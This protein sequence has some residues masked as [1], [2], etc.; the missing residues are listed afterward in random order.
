MGTSGIAKLSRPRSYAAYERERLF[1]VLDRF[2]DQSVRWVSGP[3]GAGKS[4]L[5]SSWLDRRKVK[6]CW[7]RVDDRDADPASMFHY[8]GEAEAQLNSRDTRV[9][10]HFTPEYARGMSVFSHRFFESFFESVPRPFVLV[11]DDYHD[12]PKNS[13]THEALL[14]GLEAVPED[15]GVVIL[16]R[17]DPPAL[18]ARLAVSETMALLAPADLRLNREEVAG[19]LRQQG[20]T[21]ETLISSIDSLAEGWPAGIQ[22]LLAVDGGPAVSPVP[23]AFLFDYFAAE[24]FRRM[25]E[26]HRRIL[27]CA[28]LAPPCSVAMVELIS[29]EPTAGNVLD[30]L[31]RRNYFVTREEQKGEPFYRFHPLFQDFLA[32][33]LNRSIPPQ[34]QAEWRH[35]AAEHLERI[36][37]PES[38]FPLRLALGDAQGA[39]ALVLG[40]AESMLKRGLHR[41]LTRWTLLLKERVGANSPLIDYW[42]GL[43]LVHFSPKEAIG[44]IESAFLEFRRRGDVDG[45][46]KSWVAAI[47]AIRYDH[48]GDHRRLDPW[49]SVLPQ[50]Q[51]LH[52]L[53]P[54]SPLELSVIWGSFS[55][56]SIRNPQHPAYSRIKERA[57]SLID[58]P[59]QDEFQKSRL[60]ISFAVFTFHQG[61]LYEARRLL[62]KCPIIDSTKLMPEVYSGL[63][64]ARTY[65]ALLGGD[66]EGCVGVV[67]EGLLHASVTGVYAWG[68]YIS[69]HGVLA[70]L[71]LGNLEAAEQGV[72]DISLFMDISA[73][74]SRA[75]WLGIK[76]NYLVYRGDYEE[77]IDLTATAIT[78][79]DASGWPVPGV[80][81]RVVNVLA[82]L[83]LGRT[84]ES[85]RKLRELDEL[86]AQGQGV[87]FRIYVLL[88]KAL[89]E[90]Q[91]GHISKADSL[92]REA[93]L[94]CEEQGV[95]EYGIM[96]PE[97]VAHLWARAI[98]VDGLSDVLIRQIR[99]RRLAPPHNHVGPWPIG[100]TIRT[101]PR[102]LIEKDGVAISFSGKPPRKPLELLKALV[103][104][105]NRDISRATIIS[106]LWPDADSDSAETALRV[107]LSRL[108]KILGID[109][110][111]IV[112]EGRLGLNRTICR[113]DVD[114]LGR[115]L[116]EIE[117]LAADSDAESGRLTEMA[118][119]LT[120]AYPGAFLASEAERPWMIALRERLQRRYC[121]GVENLGH[122]LEQ[123]GNNDEAIALY[124]RA[125]D[126]NNLAEAIY[127][128]LMRAQLAIG[129]RADALATFRRCREMLSI[130]LGVSPSAETQALAKSAY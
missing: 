44:L 129:Q 107:T 92:L 125:L 31:Y 114:F 56:I 98:E 32:A 115:A 78:L 119:I 105:G 88:A 83:E 30:D 118:K 13:L 2:A 5:V 11:I 81:A 37:K 109:E 76:A 55:A 45:I 90:T 58:D 10:P 48:A 23:K 71:A 52:L 25:A 62:A 102:L 100:I 72:N 130:V 40:Q 79:C 18:F 43:S 21:D 66:F 47:L 75:F 126:H 1:V 97:T 111:I 93:L 65:D 124:R 8:L 41:T 3:P 101:L 22:M 19:I 61:R 33:E 6:S 74:T 69:G 12:I 91:L 70:S 26:S 9:L 29:G 53:P 60:V 110:A 77:A 38:A 27:L 51:E 122:R 54:G 80:R 121:T 99:A 15:V 36:E 117:L 106:A 86:L 113:I 7:Y 57:T 89:L 73:A 120:D 24:V 87:V 63:L 35:L 50:L 17:E 34:Q 82:S 20:I 95:V 42:H 96:R 4:T 94:L 46:Y 16:S 84:E 85:A 127:R 112:A 49:I 128:Q 103:A 116:D 28:A 39:A 67:K 108:R 14:H 64:L 123:W 104:L 59:A 68:G